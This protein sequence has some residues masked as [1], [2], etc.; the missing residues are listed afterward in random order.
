MDL[1]L[2]QSWGHEELATLRE[3][4]EL[5]HVEVPKAMCGMAVDMLLD[6]NIDMAK[7]TAILM[8]LVKYA[9]H[10][11]IAK[12]Q[13]EL[14]SGRS[15]KWTAIAQSILTR[16]ENDDALR[17]CLKARIPCLCLGSIVPPHERSRVRLI[18]SI[19]KSSFTGKRSIIVDPQDDPRATQHNIWH[20]G[21][22]FSAIC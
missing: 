11:K 4:P 1:D 20:L 22:I 19:G 21:T 7:I 16:S 18:G 13:K 3:F 12:F 8:L 6:G 9:M 2:L 5:L 14:R 17:H 15:H 10:L